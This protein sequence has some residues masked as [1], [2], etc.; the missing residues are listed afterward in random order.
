MVSYKEQMSKLVEEA[1]AE[2]VKIVG[3]NGINT[4]DGKEMVKGCR[5]VK[6]DNSNAICVYVVALNRDPMVVNVN[7]VGI[8]KNKK[9]FISNDGKRWHPLNDKSSSHMVVAYPIP[10]DVLDVYEAL[11]EQNNI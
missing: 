10:S 4:L 6:I 11:C 8:D 7:Y 1:Y 2:C 3:K 5:V 9:L